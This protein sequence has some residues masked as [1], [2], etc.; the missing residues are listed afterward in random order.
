MQPE[1]YDVV[2]I[3]A[4][5]TGAAIARQLGLLDL[6]TAVLEK[7]EDVCTETS[8]ANSG[9]V[10]GGFDAKPGTMKARMNVRGTALMPQLC[11]DLDIP[12]SLIHI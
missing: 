5:V 10:H 12:L 7:N 2:I 8:K 11:A 4:G 6:K 9:I 3:G 1:E